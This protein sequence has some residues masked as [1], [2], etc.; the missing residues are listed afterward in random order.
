ME[1]LRFHQNGVFLLDGFSLEDYGLSSGATLY[2][3]H[4]DKTA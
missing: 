3:I 2:L 1:H 4:N